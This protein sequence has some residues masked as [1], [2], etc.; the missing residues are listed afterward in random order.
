MP[1]PHLHSSP[2][3]AL[4]S[5][6]RASKKLNYIRRTG[7]YSGKPDAKNVV[8]WSGN[9]PGQ[10]ADIDEFLLCAEHHERKEGTVYREIEFALPEELDLQQQ[11][12][13]AR[14]IVRQFTE[15]DLDGVT[16]ITPYTAAIHNH[17]G[18]NPHVHLVR[19]ERHMI[20][21]ADYSAK[22]Q[23]G[24]FKRQ[25]K[26][27]PEKGGLFKLENTRKFRKEV[28]AWERQTFEEMTNSHLEFAGRDERVDMRSYA[29]QGLNIIPQ[30]HEGP[31]SRAVFKRTG[32]K[33]R[34]MEY[35]EIVREY[36]DL[37]LEHKKALQDV[38]SSAE[39]ISDK[40]KNAQRDILGDFEKLKEIMPDIQEKAPERDSETNQAQ[41]RQPR[42]DFEP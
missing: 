10:F 18:K 14:D 15:R 32:K 17:G 4:G 27:S 34:A 8:E 11:I 25:N 19:A 7:E 1:L 28:L 35:N 30:I 38:E 5:G 2:A 23:A 12:D 22:D 29:D 33:S 20:S 6:P 16:L 39:D 3:V 42:R 41:R 31:T 13:L 40:L 37:V 21:G 24:F 36:K 26:K 9:V